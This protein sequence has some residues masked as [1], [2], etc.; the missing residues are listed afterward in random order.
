MKSQTTSI[1]ITL[2]AL[3]IV[4]FTALLPKSQAVVPAP[5]GG[6]PGGNTA[7]G[8]NALFSLDTGGFNTGVGWLSLRS[9]SDGSFNTAVGA[10]TLFANTADE[11]TACGAAALLS[12]HHGRRKHSQWSICA[13]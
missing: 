7:E 2:I 5:D 4:G 6:Y 3:L 8:Q 13:V 12:N 9:L 10:G 11:I 1:H